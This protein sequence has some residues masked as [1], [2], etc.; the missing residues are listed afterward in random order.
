MHV[1]KAA[2]SGR[3][4]PAKQARSGNPS[5][6]RVHEGPATVVTATARL[7]LIL[8]R[9]TNQYALQSSWL[10]S[11]ARACAR[12]FSPD[13]Q[14]IFTLVSAVKN[15]ISNALS[16]KSGVRNFMRII[17]VSSNPSARSD[18]EAYPSRT[19][20][21]TIGWLGKWPSRQ[22]APAG[23]PSGTT[24]RQPVSDRSGNF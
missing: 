24:K 3:R 12:T 11:V 4:R 1:S 16:G 22:A 23:I 18:F 2:G 17:S 10:R 9:E 7:S 20:P 14:V 6:M 21:G 15:S 5:R 8:V 19:A 13:S